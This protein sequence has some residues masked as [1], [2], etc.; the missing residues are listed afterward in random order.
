M[1]TLP[2]N[3]SSLEE[4]LSFLAEQRERELNRCEAFAAEGRMGGY[5]EITN[6]KW[7][8][9]TQPH[10]QPPVELLHCCFL[11][12]QCIQVGVDKQLPNGTGL[13]SP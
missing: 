8:G 4:K 3:S 1:I 2:G 10:W 12:W 7:E 9:G 13:A 11:G 6:F 5:S